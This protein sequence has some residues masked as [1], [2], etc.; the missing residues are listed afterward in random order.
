VEIEVVGTTLFNVIG[1]SLVQTN[2]TMSTM[3]TMQTPIPT[4]IPTIAAPTP[5]TTKQSPGFGAVFA[6][7]GICII[8]FIIARR[9]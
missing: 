3:V 6:V 8:G 1:Q 2:T 5:T 9:E 7:I 4:P